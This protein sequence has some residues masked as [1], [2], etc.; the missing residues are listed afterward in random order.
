MDR[1]F[2]CS[3]AEQRL[4][5]IAMNIEIIVVVLC[6]KPAVSHSELHS[7]IYICDRATALND[8]VHW[9]VRTTAATYFTLNKRCTIRCLPSVGQNW[10]ITASR[11][12]CRFDSTVDLHV[13]HIKQKNPLLL[14]SLV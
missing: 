2:I 13:L 4:F 11:A 12:V 14:V 1:I 9:V 10:N 6:L 8:L 5:D 7:A 3:S